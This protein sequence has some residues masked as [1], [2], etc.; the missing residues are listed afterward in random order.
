MAADDR[1]ARAHPQASPLLWG[2]LTCFALVIA[3]L[4]AAIKATHT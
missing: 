3:A 4:T 2:P 1:T